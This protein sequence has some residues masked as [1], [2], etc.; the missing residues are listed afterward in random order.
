MSDP[1]NE[2]GYFSDD[3][4]LRGGLLIGTWWIPTW[5]I[6]L[7]ASMVVVGIGAKPAYLAWHN[8]GTD[9]CLAAAQQAA[10][11]NQWATVRDQAHRVLLARPGDIVAHR[12]WTR[13]LAKLGDARTYQAAGSLLRSPHASREDR[14]EALQMMVAQ[15]PQSLALSAYDNLPVALRDDA[16]FR[17]ALN[18]LLLQLGEFEL[19]ETRLREVIQPTASPT[20]H[21]ELLR[22][23]CDH[24]SPDRLAEARSIFAKLI[25]NKSDGAALTAMLL[26][27]GVR[28]LGTR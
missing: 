23:L 28:W 20:V 15:A 14:L 19:A 2:T 5:L 25:S 6:I 26:L 17:A 24:P 18:P 10:A 21:L 27:G 3:P 8:H 11:S 9:G 1:S 4:H 7:V 22:V 13:A 12:L 16:E